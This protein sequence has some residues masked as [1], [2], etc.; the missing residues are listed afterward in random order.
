MAGSRLKCVGNGDSN[1]SGLG[2]HSVG[3]CQSR[4]LVI[5]VLVVGQMVLSCCA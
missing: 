2:V 1:G 5:V 4:G 3:G